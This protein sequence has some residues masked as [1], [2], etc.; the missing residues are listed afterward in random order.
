MNTHIAVL[1]LELDAEK[2]EIYVKQNIGS[3]SINTLEK[4]KANPIWITV[5]N[6]KGGCEDGTWANHENW[7]EQVEWIRNEYNAHKLPI[8]VEHSALHYLLNHE[9]ITFTYEQKDDP[10]CA[11]GE[12]LEICDICGAEFC[13]ECE[14]SCKYKDEY[15]NVEY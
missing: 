3:S 7:L 11:C 4:A 10:V 8:T 6:G 12:F 2:N 1:V 14:G 5:S 15:E 9:N 13:T